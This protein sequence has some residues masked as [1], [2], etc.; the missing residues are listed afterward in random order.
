MRLSKNF[1]T[2]E[3]RCR[4][5]C[6]LGDKPG[7]Y[8]FDTVALVQEMRDIKGGPL[9]VN[10]WLRCQRYNAMV[11]GVANSAHTRGTAVDLGANYGLGRYDLIILAVLA[12][13]KTL[14]HIPGVDWHLV[15]LTIR[16]VLRGVGVGK[17]FVHVDT[18]RISPRPSAWG[19]G[20]EGG[21]G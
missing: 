15:F 5:G 12:A 19:Y 9:A 6:G 1:T 8:P 14:H 4:C 13:V 20:S 17:S 10:S 16:D 21:G 18:D 11:G 2:E 3:C 7:E